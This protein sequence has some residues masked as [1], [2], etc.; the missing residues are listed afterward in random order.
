MFTLTKKKLY[1]EF[2]NDQLS[3]ARNPLEYITQLIDDV[4]KISHDVNRAHEKDAERRSEPPIGKFKDRRGSLWN[5]SRENSMMN[6]MS[7][8]NSLMDNSDPDLK[9][10]KGSIS[11]TRTWRKGNNMKTF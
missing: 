3:Y 11:S 6:I 8:R 5:Q 1:H 9:G 10:R 7:R 2:G 4:Q